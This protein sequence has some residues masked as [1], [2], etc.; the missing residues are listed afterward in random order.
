MGRIVRM[1]EALANKI[2]AGE[3]VE[4]PASIVKELVENALDADATAITIEV[5]EGGLEKIKITDDGHGFLPEDCL[6]AFE[7]HATSK[8]KSEKDLFHVRTLGFR[9]E[10]LPS[11]ASVSHFE[12]RTSTGEGPGRHLVLVGGRVETDEPSHS[13]KGTEMTITQLFYNTP[14]RLKY[15]KTINTELANITDV[16][17]KLALAHPDIRFHLVHNE[18]TLLK[19]NGNGDLAQVLAAIYGVETAKQSLP[20]KASS[21]DFEVEGRLVKPMI[22]RA[23]RQYVYLFINGRYI[24]HYSLFNAIMN[25]YHTLLPIGRFPIAVVHIKMDPTLVDVNVHPAKLEARISKEA[26]L[27]ELIQSAIKGVFHAQRLIPDVQKTKRE[28][29]WTEQQAMDFRPVP[30][31]TALDQVKERAVSPSFEANPERLTHQEPERQALTFQAQ[32]QP[33]RSLEGPSQRE[34]L[35]EQDV[36]DMESMSDPI[37]LSDR[38]S[39][40]PSQVIREDRPDQEFTSESGLDQNEP[41]RKRMPKLFPIGQLHGTYILAQNEEGLFIIDQHAAQ[42]RIKYEFFREKVGETGH[43][44]QELLFPLT[45]DFTAS[46]ASI[47]EENRQILSELGL[48]FEAF[49]HHSFIVRSHPNWFPKGRERETIESI[50]EEL[51]DSQ[52]VSI[53]KLREALAI[54]MSCKQS[55]KANRHLRMDEMESLLDQLIEAQDPFTC[56]HGRPVIIHFSTY[57]MEKLF[58]RVM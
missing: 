4:R 43:K 8:I 57:E 46:E 48:N 7:R 40:N 15:L 9:G 53:K 17:N 27:V 58:K 55:I 11:I 29:E 38:D 21:L 39:F 36:E 54:M 28:R 35:Q 19:T 14:A 56:P 5:K 22:S 52:S 31:K 10:A 6:L 12:L 37:D 44:N 13:R 18:K 25:G 3:V 16:V 2:A 42:E 33:S 47:I 45:F 51:I 1:D 20:L 49:G 30:G 50:V 23:G 34:I 32:D 41:E 26:E 24:R